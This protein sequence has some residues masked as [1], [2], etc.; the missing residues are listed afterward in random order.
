ML[1]DTDWF[2]WVTEGILILCVGCVGLAG[3]ACSMVI[4][5]RQRIQRAFHHLLLMLAVFD[6]VRTG[7][8]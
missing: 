4:F 8:A 3:N 6:A 7:L 1:G 2:M 5:A